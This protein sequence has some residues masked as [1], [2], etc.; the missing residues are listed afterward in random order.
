MYVCFARLAVGCEHERVLAGAVVVGRSL[1][2]GRRTGRAVVRLGAARRAEDRDVAELRG[3][4]RCVCEKRSTS[5]R[6][7]GSRVGSIDSDGMTYGLTAYA[8]IASAKNR[9]PATSMTSSSFEPG[10]RRGGRER[11]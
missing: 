4:R 5:T 7:P 9:A 10:R 11:R 2:G 1:A 3:R 8:W 6:W